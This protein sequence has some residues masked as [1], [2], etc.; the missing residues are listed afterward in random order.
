MQDLKQKIRD[1]PDFPKEGILFKDITP[2]LADG[3]A[4]KHTIDAIAEQWAH[5]QIDVIVGI[6]ARG[7]IFASALAYK[8]GIGVVIVRKPGKLPYKTHAVTYE[9]EYGRDSL[10]I[11]QDAI[12]PGQ[13]ILIIDDVLA[14][15]GTVKAVAELL[16]KFDATLT[17]IAFLA[18]LAFLNG[19]EKLQGYDMT[20]LMTF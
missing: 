11:H 19:R 10:E 15:G 6:E 17:G 7:F 1:V 2:L 20:T 5:K 9:L 4:F 18:E 13:N 8:L 16:Q 3:E 12:K 14:T